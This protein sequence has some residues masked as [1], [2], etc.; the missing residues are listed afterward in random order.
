[1]PDRGARWRKAARSP[2]LQLSWRA[3]STP[4]RA[5]RRHWTGPVYPP[6]STATRFG[7]ITAI[8][9]SIAAS[10]TCGKVFSGGSGGIRTQAVDITRL[11]TLRLASMADRHLLL[12]C[13]TLT[14]ENYNGR[15]SIDAALTGTETQITGSGTTV[16]MAVARRVVDP[17]GGWMGSPRQIVGQPSLEVRLGETYRLERLVAVH[18]SR[19]TGE[20]HEMASRQVERAIE[21]VNGAIAEHLD[22]WLV[23]W[24]ALSLTFGSRVIPR[25]SGR[26]VLPF[27]ICRVRQTRTTSAYPLAPAD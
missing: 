27:I 10:S 24:K 25:R 8:I 11:L 14:A 22:A 17:A 13:A 7:S 23:R 9:W 5:L 1:M 6:P 12:Q 18:T 19:D 26:C 16:A 3:Y 4:R 21:D 15:V 2:H 20:P